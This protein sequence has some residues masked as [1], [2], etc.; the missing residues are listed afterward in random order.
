[1][2][3]WQLLTILIT[4]AWLNLLSY[5]RQFW[6]LGVYIIMFIEILKTFTQF[7]VI[8][9][10]FI[11]AFGFGFHFLL[12]NQTSFEQVRYTMLKTSVMMIGGM[13]ILHIKNYNNFLKVL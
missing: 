8:F 9:V 11:I 6:N 4:V 10:I 5:L 1:M 7:A 3:Q 12:I 13:L 2:V